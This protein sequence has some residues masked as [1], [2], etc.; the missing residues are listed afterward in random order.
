VN[1]LET[2]VDLQESLMRLY[3]AGRERVT[4]SDA[5]NMQSSA[6]VA[7]DTRPSA[8]DP[9]LRGFDTCYVRS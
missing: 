8:D 4:L 9:E 2:R 3:S 6:R 1:L 7:E 5:E